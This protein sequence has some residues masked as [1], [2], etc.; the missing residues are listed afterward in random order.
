MT[1][2]APYDVNDLISVD[3]GEIMIFIY[4]CGI[5][6]ILNGTLIFR[7]FTSFSRCWVANMHQIKIRE[8]KK[9]SFWVFHHRWSK[10]ER[11]N[12]L[13]GLF[14]FHKILHKQLKKNSN[15]SKFLKKWQICKRSIYGIVFPILNQSYHLGRMVLRWGHVGGDHVTVCVRN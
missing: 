10:A 13:W 7:F 14:N 2:I 8:K 15:H 12:S 4:S 5:D 6:A 1:I 3:G 11:R 9:G